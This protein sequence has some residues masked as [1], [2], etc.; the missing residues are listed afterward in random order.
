MATIKTP[1]VVW[2]LGDQEQQTTQSGI[3]VLTRPL[4]YRPKA[5]E[6]AIQIGSINPDYAEPL[7]RALKKGS[8]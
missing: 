1:S 2:V 8:R 4:Y 6:R 7:I 5:G 3:T